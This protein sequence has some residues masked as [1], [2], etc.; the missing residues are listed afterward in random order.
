MSTS[1]QP[2]R[3]FFALLPVALLV[4]A[5]GCQDGG[6]PGGNQPMTT[7]ISPSEPAAPLTPTTPG[8]G[9][10]PTTETPQAAPGTPAGE[11]PAK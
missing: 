4:L 5:A 6:M 2:C 9:A 10:A 3:R 7:P 11:A 8:D 1:T